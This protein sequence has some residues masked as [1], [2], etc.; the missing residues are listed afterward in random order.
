M[1]FRYGV[2]GF[3][4][5]LFA[6]I[7]WRHQAVG[8]GPAGAPPL[9]AFCPFGGVE[10][11]PLYLT[12]GQFLAKTAPANVVALAAVLL[13]T[14]LGGAVFCGWFCPLGALGEWLYKLRLK[15]FRREIKLPAAAER[16]LPYGRYAVLG[17]I[18][19]MTWKT[20]KL[21][22]SD[23]DP[24]KQIFHMEV[25]NAAGWVVI[26]LF[27]AGSLLVERAW[28]RFLCPLGGIVGMVSRFSLLKI[29]RDEIG[30]AHV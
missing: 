21:W 11:L 16:V 17:I 29:N 30:R 18:F 8:G 13:V 27:A 12:S 20:S 14:L 5:L 4:V 6:Y 22:F 1:K 23:Y 9:D 3:F 25:E 2:Q 10:T 19:Y 24:F 7:G 26:G 15:I 28:C